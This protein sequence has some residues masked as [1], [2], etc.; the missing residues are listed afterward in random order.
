MNFFEVCD[1][2]PSLS[3]FCLSNG[4]E[5][6][7]VVKI[8]SHLKI[9]RFAIFERDF[10]L[11]Y[12]TKSFFRT[13]LILLNKISDR[14]YHRERLIRIARS[15]VRGSQH[16]ASIASRNAI[17]EY[18]LRESSKKSSQETSEL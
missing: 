13:L 14:L 15:V 17:A 8:Y 9:D 10:R 2:S 18:R 5:G 6:F 7:W 16:D 3:N 12:L 4:L 1:S 11:L